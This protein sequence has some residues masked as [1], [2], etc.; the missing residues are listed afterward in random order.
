VT[1]EEIARSLVT[2]TSS[3]RFVVPN[4]WPD[5]KTGIGYQV[6]VEV[7]YQVMNSVEQIKTI[8]IQHSGGPSLLLRDVADVR[9]GTMPGEYDRYNMKRSLTLTANIVGEDL[10]RASARV[11]RALE[12]AGTPPKGMMVDVRGQITPMW[13]ILN[14]LS[15]GLLRSVAVIVLL[16]TA[17]FQSIRLALVSVAT[18]PAVI[19]GVAVALWLTGTTINLQ[20]FMGSIMAIGVAVANA[21]LL[22]TFAERSRLAGASAREAAVRGARDRLR[23]ILMT[24]LAMM[25]GMMP[26]AIGFGE[27][28]DQTA[29][30]GRAVIGGLLASTF[31]TLL[32]LPAVFALVMAGAS[33]RSPS[34]SPTDPESP[35]YVPDAVAP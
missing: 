16:L 12:R 3:S 20:S 27:G 13:E 30:L 14:G 18:T 28:G 8:P 23:P 34:L 19:A 29:P 4:Y 25:A 21:I 32:I 7:P 10:G 24:S 33:R 2:A 1:V 6:Q 5:P 11:S 22:V 26:M 17:N 9:R 31:A 35:H 15:I